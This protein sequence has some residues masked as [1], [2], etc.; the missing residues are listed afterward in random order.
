MKNLR[1]I[2]ALFIFIFIAGIF[3]TVITINTSLNK[4]ETQIE[5]VKIQKDTLSLLKAEKK[6][7]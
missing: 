1:K 3:V 6:T 4:D 7:V 5:T 2:I